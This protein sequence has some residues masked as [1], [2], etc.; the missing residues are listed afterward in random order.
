MDAK[1]M[2]AQ[3]NSE[4]MKGKGRRSMKK[5]KTAPISE[6]AGYERPQD[7]KSQRSWCT[8]SN[9]VSAEDMRKVDIS[10]KDNSLNL[11]AAMQEYLGEDDEPLKGFYS[12][13]EEVMVE[14]K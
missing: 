4:R 6:D 14:P 12:D 8:V 9:K 5:Q 1:S 7:Y 13:D 10:G 11:E 2:A 3:A